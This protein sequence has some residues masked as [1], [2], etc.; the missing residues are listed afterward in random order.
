[1]NACAKCGTENPPGSK[2]CA[3]CGTA[4]PKIPVNERCASC[5]AESPEGSRFCKGCGKPLGASTVPGAERGQVPPINVPP[6]ARA[7]AGRPQP[8]S[9]NIHRVK[10]ILA[11]GAGL[12]AVGIF[13]MYSQISALQSAYG[14][15]A[16]VIANTGL[17]WFLIIVDLACAGLGLYAISQVNKGQYKLAKTMLIVMAALGAIFLLRGLSGPVIYILL[18][19]ALLAGGVWG[20]MLLSREEKAAV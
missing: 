10:T 1:M 9:Q 16:G 13:L 3:G 8:Q 7:A 2:F 5:G 15:Y 19:A 11:A 18:N 4:I 14:A 6:V 12:Y 17:Q 20:W